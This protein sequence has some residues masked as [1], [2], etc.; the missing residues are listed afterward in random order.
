MWRQSMWRQSMWRQ[1]MW[2]Q[3]MWRPSKGILRGPPRA[4]LPRERDDLTPLRT[5]C[6]YSI[7]V[8]LML[9]FV[10]T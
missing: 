6:K 10:D 9:Q 5:N 4:G 1:S 7:K 8:K 2:R 3:S